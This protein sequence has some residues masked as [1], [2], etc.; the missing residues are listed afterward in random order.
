ME[1]INRVKKIKK[2]VDEILM[3]ES[4]IDKNVID[5]R[6][7]ILL[8]EEKLNNILSDISFIFTDGSIDIKTKSY[9]IMVK[10]VMEKKRK[11]LFS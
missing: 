11:D 4:M 10:T 5:F 6:Y 1:K 2:D 7:L 3:N 8:Q 9:L